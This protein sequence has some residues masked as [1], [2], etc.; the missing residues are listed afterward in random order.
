KTKKDFFVLHFAHLA[1][2]FTAKV[3]GGSEVKTKKDFFVLHFA[4]L[5]LLL[6][7]KTENYAKEFGNSRVSCQGQNH[8]KVS[9][10]RL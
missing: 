6:H 7:H 2:L 9:W 3:G 5:A 4:H 10:S 8:R 1:L